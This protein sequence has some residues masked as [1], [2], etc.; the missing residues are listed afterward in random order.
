MNMNTCHYKDINTGIYSSFFGKIREMNLT[1]M[2]TEIKRKQ[3]NILV[4]YMK[5]LT[6]SFKT[7]FAH[8]CF[9]L[10]WNL[11]LHSVASPCSPL[12]TCSLRLENTVPPFGGNFTKKKN[13]DKCEHVPHTHTHTAETSLL[14]LEILLHMHQEVVKAVKTACR[15]WWC[16]VRVWAGLPATE[17]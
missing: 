6:F 13:C 3:E 12:S 4:W 17:N 14:Y 9:V 1:S 8:F 10:F 11:R 5:Q 7:N 15:G 16:R 2:W